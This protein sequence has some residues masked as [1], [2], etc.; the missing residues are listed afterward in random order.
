MYRL[1]YRFGYTPWDKVL[2]AELAEVIAGSEALAPGRALDMGSGNGT[3]AIFMAAHGWRVTGVEAIPRAITESLRRAGNAGVK[4]DFR[5]GD[6]TRLD[7]LGL[8]PGYNL[9]FDFGCYHGLN[10]NQRDAY[11][12]GVNGVAG[13]GAT[14]LMMGFTKRAPP[15]TVPVTE[16]DLRAHFGPDWALAW[17]H[18]DAS[19][20]T[21]AMDRAA[22]C[23]FCLI[24]R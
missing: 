23:W 15:V 14:L 19:K 20:G 4:V 6:V 5:E 2:P 10:G 24:R 22:A 17:S 9:I 18:P 8:E 1:M 21:W 16:T 13:D 11:V 7:D 3:K 12:R